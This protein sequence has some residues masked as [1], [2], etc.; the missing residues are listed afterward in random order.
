MQSDDTK[1]QPGVQIQMEIEMTAKTAHWATQQD[2]YSGDAAAVRAMRSNDSAVQ[3]IALSGCRVYE[4]RNAKVSEIDLV[5]MTWTIPAE[6]RKANRDYVVPITGRM[7]ELL[8]NAMKHP[9]GL[10]KGPD[11]YLFATPRLARLKALHGIRTAFC[12]W[13][14]AHA[15]FYPEPVH[16]LNAVEQAYSR[17]L[18]LQA[19][20]EALEAWGEYLMGDANV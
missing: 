2:Q 8:T 17:K 13:A 14:T 1:K 10:A 6:R 11:D 5:S 19:R 7:A 4:A 18:E 20:R 15:E 9:S 16:Y 3:W 12:Q